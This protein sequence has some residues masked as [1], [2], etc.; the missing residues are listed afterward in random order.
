MSF[1]PLSWNEYYSPSQPEP[2]VK[3]SEIAGHM[4]LK[5]SKK[6]AF[7][8]EAGTCPR[9]IYP[10]LISLSRLKRCYADA[11]AVHPLPLSRSN[12][13]SKIVTTPPKRRQLM[14]AADFF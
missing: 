1:D 7:S 11:L 2:H 13:D 9:N 14:K 6:R 5:E 4:P 3:E 8:P 12:A 10:L